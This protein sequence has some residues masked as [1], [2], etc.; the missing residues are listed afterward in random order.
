[1]ARDFGAKV[2][3]VDR[4]HTMSAD[5]FSPNA[6]G[7][8]LNAETISTLNSPV[9]CGGANNQL[10]S[11]ANGRDLLSRGIT[12]VPDYVANAGGI[13][14]VMAEYLGEAADGVE[15]RVRAIGPRVATILEQARM[16]HRP[17]NDISDQLAQALIDK[18]AA[19]RSQAARIRMTAA[20]KST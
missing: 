14:N 8:I 9:V 12:Y 18:A 2:V 7:A 3:S 16:E 5:V 19:G 13:I 10:A 17:S 11:A 20:G 1:M 15:A 4:I 6:L